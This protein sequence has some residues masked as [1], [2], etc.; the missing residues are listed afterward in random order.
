M[1]NVEKIRMQYMTDKISIKVTSNF[2]KEDYNKF[3]YNNPNTSVFQTLEMAEVYKRN[4]NTQP[5]ILIAINEDTGEILASLLAKILSHK[6]G[7]LKSFTS[8]STIRGGPIFKNDADG[9]L[10][11]LELLNHYN[12]VVKKKHFIAEF[13][14]LLIYRVYFQLLSSVDMNIRIGRIFCYL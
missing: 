4:K 9:I 5:L 1:E 8:H 13:T 2:K 12:E 3:V 6:S 10:A 11:T 14:L 7:Y